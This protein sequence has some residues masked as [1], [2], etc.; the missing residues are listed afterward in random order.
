MDV[1]SIHQNI[2]FV[3][4][5][6]WPSCPLAILIASIEVAMGINYSG[7]AEDEGI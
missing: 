5:P 3:Q 1:V 2:K 4:T 7:Y 6:I